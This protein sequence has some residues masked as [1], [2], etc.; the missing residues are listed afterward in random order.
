MRDTDAWLQRA[1]DRVIKQ[2]PRDKESLGYA[3]VLPKALVGNSLSNRACFASCR[4][5]R[6]GYTARVSAK[7]LSAFKYS[8]LTKDR[9]RWMEDAWL[10]GVIWTPV[11]VKTTFKDDRCVVE[12]IQ[13][14][15]VALF[16]NG[17]QDIVVLQIV[18]SG[19]DCGSKEK[20][21]VLRKGLFL[22]D[23]TRCSV[24]NAEVT[25]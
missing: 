17:K 21:A 10:R 20:L 5:R 25:L 4:H 11:Y 6:K 22:K 15:D 19:N 1:H 13:D 8:A 12:D 7:K 18:E 2:R 9:Q 16:L 24:L 14:Y 3:G 23:G